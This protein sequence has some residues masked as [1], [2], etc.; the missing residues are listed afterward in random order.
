MR[1]KRTKRDREESRKQKLHICS[2]ELCHM[3]ALAIVKAEGCWVVSQ[4]VYKTVD[5]DIAGA[6]G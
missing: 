5:D 1:N 4:K 3:K 2:F 6:S